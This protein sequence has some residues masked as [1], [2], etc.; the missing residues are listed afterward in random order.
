[1]FEVC[2]GAA[3]PRNFGGGGDQSGEEIGPLPTLPVFADTTRSDGKLS[4]RWKRKGMA[5]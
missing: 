2:T 5:L 4:K 1:L 3:F